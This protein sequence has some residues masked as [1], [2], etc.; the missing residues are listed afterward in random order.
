MKTI[1]LIIIFALSGCA[2]IHNIEESADGTVTKDCTAFY[3]A[4]MGSS[5]EKDMSAC[6]GVGSSKDA[7]TDQAIKDM[8][9][10]AVEAAKMAIKGTP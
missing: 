8:I 6:G 4:G 1:V 7:Q 5:A 3:F 2:G 9:P 10:I